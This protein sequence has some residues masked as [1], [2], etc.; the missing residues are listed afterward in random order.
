MLKDLEMKKIEVNR[1]FFH[2]TK[3][4]TIRVE[5]HQVNV[6]QGMQLSMLMDRYV[7]Y[8]VKSHETALSEMNCLQEHIYHVLEQENQPYRNGSRSASGYDN[9]SPDRDCPELPPPYNPDTLSLSE[10]HT[11]LNEHSML[12]IKDY[13]DNNSNGYDNMSEDPDCPELPPPYDPDSLD[14][15]LSEPCV[16]PVYHEI[17]DFPVRTS[18]GN[19]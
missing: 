2:T 1:M 16:G 8:T 19:C 11:E 3:L 14:L 7:I 12:Q 10:H 15:S 6:Q 13:P 17:K 4:N 18:V 9:M 5:L